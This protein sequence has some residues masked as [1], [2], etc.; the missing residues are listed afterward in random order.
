MGRRFLAATAGPTEAE[1]DG[2]K[3]RRRRKDKK[4]RRDRKRKRR[5]SKKEN[6][7]ENPV[8]RRQTKDGTTSLAI[9]PPGEDATIDAETRMTTLGNVLGRVRVGTSYLY[10]FREDKRNI[11]KAM[12]PLSYNFYSSYGPSYDSTFS[13]LTLEESHLVQTGDK[14]KATQTKQYAD[15][16]RSVCLDDYTNTFVDHM[17]DI[18]EGKEGPAA[19]AATTDDAEAAADSERIDFAALKS[20]SDDGIDMSFLDNLQ[21]EYELLDPDKRKDD[22]SVEERL[23]LTAELLQNLKNTQNARL[24]AC[25]NTNLNLVPA[26]SDTEMKLASRV[27]EN[28]SSIINNTTP[29]HLVNIPAIRKAMGINVGGGVQPVE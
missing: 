26:P 17:I 5:A 21:T 2:R 6:E 10:G 3:E 7:N 20:L 8:F 1:K 12:Y 23:D 22:A 18:L 11:V 9:L 27:L 4:K 14:F 13:N 28:L 24:S 25:P 19:P 29:A 15:I 16:I